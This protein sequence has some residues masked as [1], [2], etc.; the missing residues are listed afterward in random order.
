MCIAPT[1][2]SSHPS[3]LATANTTSPPTPHLTTPFFYEN[4]SGALNWFGK[5]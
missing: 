5:Q 4:D 3:R 1:T 2:P